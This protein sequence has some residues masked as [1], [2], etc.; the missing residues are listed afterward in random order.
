VTEMI[1][2]LCQNDQ[3]IVIAPKKWFNKP[4]INTQDIIPYTW[5]SL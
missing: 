1:I 3:K 2:T 5:I 4:E